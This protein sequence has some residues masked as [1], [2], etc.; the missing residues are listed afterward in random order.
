MLSPLAHHARLMKQ[1]AL[2][3]LRALAPRPD[4]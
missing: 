4:E 3:V 2:T 1:T